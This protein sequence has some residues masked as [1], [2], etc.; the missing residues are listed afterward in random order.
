MG[1][2]EISP[3]GGM[4]SDAARAEA[5]QGEYAN[6]SNQL[7]LPENQEDWTE[8]DIEQL[9]SF[10]RD[11]RKLAQAVGYGNARCIEPEEAAQ[12]AHTRASNVLESWHTLNRIVGR[13]EETLKNYWMNSSVTHQRDI[14][15][16]AWPGMAEKHRPDLLALRSES[17][18][19]RQAGTAYVDAFMWPQ[20][21]LKDLTNDRGRLMQLFLNSRARSPPYAFATADL[22]ALRTGQLSKAIQGV[23]LP[24][25]DIIMAGQTAET[26]GKICRQTAEENVE[27][28][29]KGASFRA[30]DGMDVLEVQERL[31][32]FLV[33]FCQ[34]IIERIDD[35]DLEDLEGDLVLNMEISHQTRRNFPGYEDMSQVVLEAPYI[36]PRDV[37]LERLEIIVCNRLREAEAHFNSLRQ[38]PE[39]FA[40]TAKAWTGQYTKNFRE[41]QDPHVFP[42]VADPSCRRK[43]LDRA[44]GRIVHNS[45]EEIHVWKHLVLQLQ[46]LRELQRQ[47]PGTRNEDVVSSE[48]MEQPEYMQALQK[49]KALIDMRLHNHYM[50]KI[51]DHFSLY[52]P[53]LDNSIRE[54]CDTG[55]E[56]DQT[57][58]HDGPSETPPDDLL[59]IWERFNDKENLSICGIKTISGEMDRFLST[60]PKHTPRVTPLLQPAFSDISMV[61]G[62]REQFTLLW[63]RIFAPRTD[64]DIANR[65]QIE[66]VRW[67]QRLVAPIWGLVQLLND[68]NGTTNPPIKLGEA[69]DPDS[70]RFDCS[71]PEL[72]QSAEVYLKSFWDGFERDVKTLMPPR[73]YEDLQ[74]LVAF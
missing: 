11:R 53:Q 48:Y 15:R 66:V 50:M 28:I 35:K 38:D 21:N 40:T 73:E 2:A 3:K 26:Y 58:H 57:L 47:Y 18:E 19:Q 55:S 74:E 17:Q 49:L 23:F 6:M 37:D 34:L 24:G 13:H 30:G 71:S 64:K 8:K 61:G 32:A 39:Y 43:L 69:G 52:L 12:E 27:A 41:K 4:S 67:G 14:L 10:L 68:L 22:Q 65:P 36:E 54:P 31:M 44:I 7:G 60:F 29:A 1:A 59:W 16:E 5:A 20:I 70:G 25:H 63:P 56:V 62:L 45:Y 51:N 72:R 9:R 46:E 33:K 42:A